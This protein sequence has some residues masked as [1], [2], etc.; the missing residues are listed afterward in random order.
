MGGKVRFDVF[1]IS[2]LL[3]EFTDQSVKMKLM[4]G[5]SLWC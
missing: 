1:V 4:G 2:F 5:A 3:R